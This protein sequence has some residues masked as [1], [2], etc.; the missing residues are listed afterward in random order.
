MAIG[1]KILS[2][3][4][5]STTPHPSSPQQQK[6]QQQQ[7]L[8]LKL[9]LKQQQQQR[10]GEIASS[11][12]IWKDLDRKANQENLQN[13]SEQEEQPLYSNNLTSSVVEDKA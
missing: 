2:D 6:Q 1:L 5:I 3:I 12:R 4:L 13:W 8:K 9:K 10:K 7:Q 11:C